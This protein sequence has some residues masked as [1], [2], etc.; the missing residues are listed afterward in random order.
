L[1]GAV[2]SNVAG[3]VS[4]PVVV[5]THWFDAFVRAVETVTLAGIAL[6][7]D[8]SPDVMFAPHFFAYA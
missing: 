4:A 5:A 6:S 7:G 1:N 3:V 8:E 2:F